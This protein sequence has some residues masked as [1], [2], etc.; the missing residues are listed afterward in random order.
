MSRFSP[1]ILP[2]LTR[3][4]A[5]P[6]HGHNFCPLPL[7]SYLQSC[8]NLFAGA[9]LPTSTPFTADSKNLVQTQD[10]HG[11]FISVF[12]DYSLPYCNLLEGFPLFPPYPQTPGNLTYLIWILSPW[13]FPEAHL[14]LF[15]SLPL[16]LSAMHWLA[17][18]YSTRQTIATK[19]ASDPERATETKKWSI[20][21]R[22]IRY[23][24]LELNNLTNLRCL[25][26]SAKLQTLITK[27]ICFHQNP[28]NLL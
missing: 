26:R 11:S 25:N 1:L 17:E 16:H 12:P 21:S 5:N 3:D 8:D 28:V 27:I 6:W 24:Y 14:G 2:P 15:F 13:F 18:A 19:L 10:A 9:P 7:W 20:H 4:S 23:Q 22:K